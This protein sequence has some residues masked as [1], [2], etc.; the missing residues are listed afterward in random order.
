MKVK[1]EHKE[2]CLPCI[3]DEIMSQRLHGEMA[4]I[5]LIIKPE[6]K[7]NNKIKPIKY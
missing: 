6:T 7:N 1:A 3:F 2:F 5:L 4:I